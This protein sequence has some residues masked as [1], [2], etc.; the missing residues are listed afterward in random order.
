[1][2]VNAVAFYVAA[3]LVVVSALACVAMPEPRHAVAAGLAT[4]LAVA[5]LLAVTGAYL[6]AVVV[7]VL[8]AAAALWIWMRARQAATALLDPATAGRGKT[9]QAGAAVATVAAVLLT[10]AVVQGGGGWAPQGQGGDSLISVL[11]WREPVAGLLALA[12]I[13]G[14]TLGAWLIGHESADEK[15]YDAARDERRRKQEK[16]ER[17]RTDRE[18]ARA[19]RGGRA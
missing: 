13:L 17:R 19:G 7:A 8:P 10:W 18:V 9:W 1:M 4:V 3:V 11:H 16:I 2:T 5:I 6:V 12:L 15:A 14:G